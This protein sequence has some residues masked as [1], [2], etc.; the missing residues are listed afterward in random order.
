ML[1]LGRHRFIFLLIIYSNCSSAQIVIRNNS[2]IPEADTMNIVYA[3]VSNYMEA[4]FENLENISF[5]RTFKKDTLR[6][7]GFQSKFKLEYS[8]KDIGVYDTVIIKS[9]NRIIA[10]KIYHVERIPDPVCI[11]AA[12]RDTIIT[13]EQVLDHPW[14]DVILPDC[15]FN[16]DEYVESYEAN[17]I[18]G[19]RKL[20]HIN[21]HSYVGTPPDFDFLNKLISGDKIHFQDIRLNCPDCATRPMKSFTIT[22]K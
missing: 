22:I 13:K 12:T 7:K 8:W 3:G 17:F 4:S 19:K 20:K 6:S 11:F 9:G 10:Q 2:L 1:N 21:F 14:M 18:R 5:S 15:Y 16:S